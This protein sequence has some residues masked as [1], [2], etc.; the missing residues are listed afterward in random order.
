MPELT[1][2]TIQ[3]NGGPRDVDGYRFGDWAATPAHGE[4]RTKTIHADRVTVVYDCW[5][6][7]YVPTGCALGHARKDLALIAARFLRRHFPTIATPVDDR[8]GGALREV[9][10]AVEFA[11]SEGKLRRELRG[12]ARRY[13]TDGA[14]ALT[15]EAGDA[16]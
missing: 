3:T 12:A 6:V 8:T 4:A 13:Q 16:T 7:T 14:R 10:R 11:L 15:T 2:V 5:T 1:T 9:R